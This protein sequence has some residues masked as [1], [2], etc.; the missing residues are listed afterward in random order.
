MRIDAI[1]CCSGA[2]YADQLARSL[3]IWLETLDS[4][5]V[6]TKPN[7]PAIEMLL[8][9]DKR[10][11]RIVSTS[12]FTD[13]GADF[14]KGAALCCAY[15]AAEPTSWCL[16][17]DADIIPPTEWREKVERHVLAGNLYGAPRVLESGKPGD[18]KRFCPYG[19]F[20][21]WNVNDPCSWRW[22][23]FDTWHGHCGSYDADF[24]EQWQQA[25]WKKLPFAVTHQGDPRSNWFGEGNKDKMAPLVKRG[26]RQY[27]LDCQNE[28]HPDR[29]KIPKPELRYVL[30]SRAPTWAREVIRLA[31]LGGPF[32]VQV[33]T[34]GARKHEITKTTH[35]TFRV[36]E[37]ILACLAKSLTALK[38][39]TAL[40]SRSFAISAESESRQRLVLT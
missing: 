29:L 15:A 22:P 4:L 25:R 20:Q 38:S 37:E 13:Y 32:R 26:L 40:T 9:H 34:Q 31:A 24:M 35:S 17:F 21:L 18:E 33:S 3:P 7:D 28:E 30:K 16:H 27:R 36:Q 39:I 23:M 6:V 14:N 2:L 11:L 5:T 1:T 8:Q 19:Y 12:V 10:N